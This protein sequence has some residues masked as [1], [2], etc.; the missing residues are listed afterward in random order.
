MNKVTPIRPAVFREMQKSEPNLILV[1]VRTP[2]EHRMGHIP[3]SRLLPLNELPSKA[4]AILTDKDQ[5]I[6]V[7]CA[8][9]ARSNQAAH[10]LSRLGYTRIHDMGG[11]MSW[12]YEIVTGRT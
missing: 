6:V 2:D 8:S 4:P 7:Y 5:P 11:I 10:F 1:D 3:S 12:P 9:G